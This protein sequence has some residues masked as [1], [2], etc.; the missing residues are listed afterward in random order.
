MIIEEE[1][2]QNDDESKTDRI[3]LNSNAKHLNSGVKGARILRVLRS[4]QKVEK[5]TKTAQKHMT[6][7]EVRRV[8]LTKYF[9]HHILCHQA[10]TA[11]KVNAMI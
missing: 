9:Q 1:Y 8:Q 10:L 5:D 11:A 4:N 7:T 3:K 2:C 6:D